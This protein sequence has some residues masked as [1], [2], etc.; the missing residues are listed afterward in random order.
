MRVDGNH[1]S[2]NHYEPN[3][4]GNWTETPEAALPMEK[5]GDAFRY[6]FRADDHDY[7]TQAG[8]LWNAM[9]EDQQKVL[10]ANTA[11]NMGDSTLQIKHRHI[12]NCYHADPEYG[13]GVAKAL[14]ID[15]EDVD[16]NLPKRD[17]K[18]NN[19]KA[20]NAHPELDVE[21]NA[22]SDIAEIKTDYN[23]KKFIDPMD[24]PYLL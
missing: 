14:N 2:E 20:N 17:S 10:C 23:P 6:D 1:G 4:Y 19:Y 3:S 15:I 16:L 13:K 24:D 9:T 7:Y 22:I 18:D 5:A 12:N 11:R 21:S 8:M